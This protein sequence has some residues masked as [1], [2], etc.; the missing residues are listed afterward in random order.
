MSLIDYKR[1]GKILMGNKFHSVI[2]ANATNHE[3]FSQTD[4]RF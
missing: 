2:L 1:G 3:Q 4:Q